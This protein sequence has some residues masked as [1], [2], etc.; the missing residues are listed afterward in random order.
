MRGLGLG[1]G[2]EMTDVRYEHFRNVREWQMK[3]ELERLRKDRAYLKKTLESTQ[4]LS[5][6]PIK[7]ETVAAYR[8]IIGAERYESG[9]VDVPSI[10]TLPAAASGASLPVGF[11]DAMA[12]RPGEVSISHAGG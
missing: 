10:P 6:D 9:G 8:R 11:G 7:P 2:D 3:R 1:H 4:R 12:A 5:R